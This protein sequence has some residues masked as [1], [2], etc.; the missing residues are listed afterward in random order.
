M[1]PAIA[2]TRVSTEEQAREGVSLEAQEL[3]IA[4]YCMAHDLEIIESCT[5]AG[6]S[7]KTI[8]ARPGLQRAILEACEHKAALVVYSLSR[9]SRSTRDTIDLAEKLSRHGADLVSVTEHIDTTTAAG[10]M[11]FGIMA[12][13]NQFE[14]EQLAERVKMGMEQKKR[15]GESTGT[16]PYGWAVGENGKTLVENEKEQTNIYLIKSLHSEGMSL[17]SIRAYLSDHKIPSRSGST[18][19]RLDTINKIIKE[20]E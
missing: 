6:I 5:D 4:A 18:S 3:R 12:V 16:P 10:K 9:A 1:K 11:F 19:W 8:E 14:R 20:G 7:G 17:R 13:L 2:Y 15:K